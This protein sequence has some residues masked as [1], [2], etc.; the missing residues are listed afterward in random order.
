VRVL[1]AVICEGASD[2]PDGR[3]DMHGVFH[4]LYAPGFPAQ[5]DRMVLAVAVEWEGGEHGR[6]TFRIDLLDPTRTPSLTI[7][8][9]T[10]ITP[11]PPGEAPPQTRLVLP[12]EGIV[13]P[14][15]GTYL[16]QLHVGEQAVPLAPL[17]LVEHEGA[18][19]P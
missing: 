17:H 7:N 9:H 5:Q 19:E 14:A 4:Q 2:R 12:L 1:Y 13:F 6:Q 16:F 15:A 10:D 18:V 3:M 8:G 11:T